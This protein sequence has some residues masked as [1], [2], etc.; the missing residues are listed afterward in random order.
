[1]LLAQRAPLHFGE[2]VTE[3]FAFI[4]KTQATGNDRVRDE[5]FIWT[6]AHELRQPLSVM[7]TAVAIM[8]HDSPA[9]A[10]PQATAV[11]SSSAPAHGTDGR[12]LA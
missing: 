3:P 10:A 11:M 8:E 2:A 4:P 9:G 5:A 1:M 6:L 7:T 12:R